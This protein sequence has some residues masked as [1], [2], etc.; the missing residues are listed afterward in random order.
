MAHCSIAESNHICLLRILKTKQG[1]LR[2]FQV[3]KTKQCVRPVPQE[4]QLRAQGMAPKEWAKEINSSDRRRQAISQ[5]K[6]VHKARVDMTDPP[7]HGPADY[8]VVEAMSSTMSA[9]APFQM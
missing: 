9:V 6:Q 1:E 4:N 3:R 5:R 8:L 7:V 2:V